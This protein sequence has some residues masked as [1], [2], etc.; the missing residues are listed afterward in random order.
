MDKSNLDP[1]LQAGIL[2]ILEE[3]IPEDRRAAFADYLLQ[4]TGCHNRTRVGIREFIEAPQYLNK[5]AE[6]YPGIME[7]LVELTSGDYQE[8]VLTGAIGT[9]KTTI[10]IYLTA[11]GLYELSLLRDPHRTFGLDPTSE[12]V[13]VFQS[14]T[15]SLAKSVD[16]MRFRALIDSS[17]YFRDHF[18]YDRK[19]E[20]EMRFPNRILVKPVSGELTG[21]I[22]Q[23]IIAG[24]IDEVNHMER[25]E[26]SRKAVDGATY[27]QAK[28]LY[29]S[30]VR[31]RKSRFMQKG[32]LPGVL[33]LVG[34]K[35][36]P[37][38]FTDQRVEAAKEDRTIYVFDKR[39]W[40]VLPEDRFSGEWFRVFTGDPY[41]QPRVL[42]EGEEVE[43]RDH[44]LVMRVPIEYREDFLRDPHEAL[45]EIGGISSLAVHPFFVNREAVAD[46]FGRHQSILDRTEVELKTQKVLFHPCRVV[47]PAEPR[48]IHIDLSA[49]QDA[50]GIVCGHVAGFTEMQRGKDVEKLPRIHIDF[51]LRV[52][53]PNG[54]EIDFSVIRKI[55]YGLR[56][57][58]MNIPWVSLDSFQSR[59]FIQ[60]LLRKGFCSGVSSVDKTLE[61]YSLAKNAIYDRRIALPADK[62]LMDE[63]LSVEIDYERG[64]VDHLPG[65]TKDVADALAGVVKG[66]SSRTEIWLRHGVSPMEIPSHTRLR[67]PHAS[68]AGP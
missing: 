1:E 5:P 17:P 26:R 42:A 9:G 48:W 64:K 68:A 32:R 24:V 23:N 50:T 20:S 16:Y 30:I 41:R 33:C 62:R 39:S 55:I 43:A 13:F 15:A 11:Y 53:P 27:D 31:R 45:R 54:G 37:G 34:S 44:E 40:E 12:I 58:G 25:V 4:N 18:P 49:T 60:Q 47:S 2:A 29:S 63:L 61:A 19:V 14:I 59:D 28:A 38:Q 46:C 51:S 7:V 21:T 52:V 8:A 10:A 66:L 65:K 56:A 36:Y 35:R 57:H 3:R 22:G 6:V 67:A